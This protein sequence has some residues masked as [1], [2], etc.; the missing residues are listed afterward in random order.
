MSAKTGAGLDAWVEWLDAIRRPDTDERAR[1]AA[2]AAAPARV[3]A[4]GAWLKNRACLLDGARWHWSALHGDL[5]DGRACRRARGLRAGAA[6]RH[7]GVDASRTTCTRTSTARAWPSALARAARRAGGRRAAPPRAHRRGAGRA[8]PARQPVIGL[9]LDGV[10]LG[11]D[12]TA[13]GGELLWVRRR[14]VAAARPP[15]PAGAARRRRRGARAL[16]HGRGG[17]AR[18]GPRR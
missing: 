12:G 10:G 2:T 7:G 5:G 11:S 6:R 3:L 4:C 13:W 15:E 16:A 9:A 14:A 1:H 8:G 17:A 18:A